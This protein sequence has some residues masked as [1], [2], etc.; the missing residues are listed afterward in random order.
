MLYQLVYFCKFNLFEVAL[1]KVDLLKESRL[2]AYS[3]TF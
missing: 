3:K 1:N 2:R